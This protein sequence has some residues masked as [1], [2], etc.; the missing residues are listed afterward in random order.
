MSADRRCPKCRGRVAEPAL[1]VNGHPQPDDPYERLAAVLGG[2]I[3]YDR[4][5][6]LVAAKLRGFVADLAAQAPE[7]RQLVDAHAVARLTG[8]SA[9]WV[10][11]H[12]DELGAIRAGEGARPRLRFDPGLVRARLEQ[13]NGDTPTPQTP[14]PA[15][16]RLPSAELLPVKDRAA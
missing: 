1:C 3:D 4:L 14:A 5:A 2:H 8:M 11:D 15:P 6:D 12:A 9:Q 13:R 16:R 10:Y 7:L